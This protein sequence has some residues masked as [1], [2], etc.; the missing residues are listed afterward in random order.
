[1]DKSSAG[2]WL[3]LRQD[4]FTCVRWKV[5]LQYSPLV[6]CIIKCNLIKS[7]SSAKWIVAILWW[8]TKHFLARHRL[9]LLNYAFPLLQSV[10]V[11]HS[12]QRHTAFCSSRGPVWSSTSVRSPSQA[13]PLGTTCLTVFRA[14]QHVTSLDSVWRLISSDNHIGLACS[15]SWTVENYVPIFAVRRPCSKSK[16]DNLYRGSNDQDRCRTATT[17]LPLFIGPMMLP[18]TGVLTWK[19]SQGTKLYCCVNNLPKVVARQCSGCMGVELTICP[20]RVQRPNHYTTEPPNSVVVVS[21]DMLR[22]LTNCDII[23]IIFAIQLWFAALLCGRCNVMIA[24]HGTTLS[25]S[26][27]RT[28]WINSP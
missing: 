15:F 10:L 7:N 21:T 18:H 4:V 22:H 19:P 3:R 28:T 20:S 25:A 26:D 23:I 14:H 1:M 13:L 17:I 9:T 11:L 12:G 5:T 27:A 16:V 24:M 2:L 6:R 8:C